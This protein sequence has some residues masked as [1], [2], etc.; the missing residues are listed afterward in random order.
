MKIYNEIHI[1]LGSVECAQIRDSGIDP[2]HILMLVD[3]LTFGPIVP[4]LDSRW[5]IARRDFLKVF[6]GNIFDTS[7]FPS[8]YETLRNSLDK[9][10]NAKQIVLWAGPSLDE[11]LIFVWIVVF[12]NSLGVDLNKLQYVLVTHDSAENRSIQCLGVLSPDGFA[13]ARKTTKPFAANELELI[14]KAWLAWSSSNPN[15]ISSFLKLNHTSNTLSILVSRFSLLLRYYPSLVSGLSQLDEILLK[16][17][18]SHGPNSVRIT[19]EYIVSHSNKPDLIGDQI[20]KG[21]LLK[22]ASSHLKFPLLKITGEP[23]EFRQPL[24]IELT[25]AGKAVLVGEANFVELNGIDEWIGGV[26]LK[27]PPGAVWYFDPARDKLTLKD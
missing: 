8:D 27:S 10:N 22:L 1:A 2:E 13:L 23:K 7:D 26:H 11:Q 6:L 3:R 9:L 15:D 17:C 20:V 4:L 24:N 5:S 19:A 14:F 12:L 18:H 21:L 16:L 25:D